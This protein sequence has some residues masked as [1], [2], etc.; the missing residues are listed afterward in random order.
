VGFGGN[1][2]ILIEPKKGTRFGVTYVSAVKLSFTDKPQFKNTDNLPIPPNL[3]GL[4]IGMTVP[5]SVMLGAYHELNAQW[6]I[7]ADVGW[8]NW[9]Q[10]GTVDV[11][12]DSATP[13]NITTNLK[14]KDTWHGAI[15]AQ[16]RATERWTFM[17]GFAYDSSC[18]DDADRTLSLPIGEA[19]RIGLGAQW[20]MSKSVN[21]AAAY[22]FV[23]MGDL[24][25]T[26]DSTYRGRVSGSY[27]NTS[28]QFVSIGVQWKF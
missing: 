21:L 12:V 11:G 7:M 9:R 4:D 3:P 6:A 24:P 22:E 5:Q 27:N 1:A 8:Q 19:Y 26:Q 25:V 10:F 23:W 2:G 20:Q 15:G 17:T 18:V 13:T 28:I 14:Y 16:F